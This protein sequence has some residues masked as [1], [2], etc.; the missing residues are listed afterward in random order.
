MAQIKVLPHRHPARYLNHISQGWK[1]SPPPLP[2]RILR[3][4]EQQGGRWNAGKEAGGKKKVADRKLPLFCSL[5]DKGQDFLSAYSHMSSITNKSQVFPSVR[6]WIWRVLP[7]VASG[8]VLGCAGCRTQ[9][10]RAYCHTRS[11]VAF[12]LLLESTRLICFTERYISVVHKTPAF[13]D[14]P[15]L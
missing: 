4:D 11:D 9:E 3:M 2:T 10:T 12:I 5:P 7:S 8:A 13:V 6:C 1:D 15:V 14:P